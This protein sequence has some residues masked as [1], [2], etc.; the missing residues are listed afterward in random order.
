MT[1]INEI[2]TQRRDRISLILN[3]LEQN[4]YI[5]S[6]DTPNAKFYLVTDKGL[7][8]YLKWIKDFLIFIRSMNNV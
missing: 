5:K 3:K 7:N 6:I 2:K 1:K 8:A 4:G